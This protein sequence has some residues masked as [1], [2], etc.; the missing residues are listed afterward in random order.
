MTASS[1]CGGWLELP[2]TSAQIVFAS[3]LVCI[4]DLLVTTSVNDAQCFNA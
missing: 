3:V 4:G 2:I 1:H